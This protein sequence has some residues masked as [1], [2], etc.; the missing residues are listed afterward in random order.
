MRDA[1]A[2]LSLA[3]SLLAFVLAQTVGLWLLLNL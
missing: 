1:L 2:L 3:A